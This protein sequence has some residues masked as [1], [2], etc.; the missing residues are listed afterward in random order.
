MR[1]GRYVFLLCSI[2]FLLCTAKLSLHSHYSNDGKTS[3][4]QKFYVNGPSC[5][6]PEMNPFSVDIMKFFKRKHFGKCSTDKDLVVSEFDTDLRQ[7]RIKVDENLAEQLLKKFDNATLKCTYQV[8]GR[9]KKSSFPDKDFSQSFLVPKTI[10]FIFTECHAVREKTELK[11]LQKDAFL[12]VQNRLKHRQKD[13]P[14]DVESKP[15]VIILGIDST[16]RMN[17]RRSMPKVHKF[18]QKPGWFEMQGYNEV[19]KNTLPNLLALLTGNAEKKA[20]LNGQFRRSGFIDK[21]KYIWQLFKQNGYMTAFGEDCG[22][23]NTFNNH[24]SGFEKQP[25]DYYLRNF[26][27]ALET[28]FK[29]RRQFGNVFCLGRKLSF[30][31]LFDFAKQFMQRFQNAAPVF[32]IFWSNSFTHGDFLGATAL[33]QVFLEYLL[34]YDK[35]GFFDRSIV[36]V[37]SDH[38]YRYGVTRQRSKSGYLEERLPIMFIHVPPWFRK[39]YPQHVENLKINQNRLSSSFD[40]HLTLHHLLQL[41]AT[42]MADFSPKLQ[43]SQCKSCQSLFFQL[44]YDRNCFQAGIGEKWCSCEPTE[45]ETNQVLIRKVAREVVRHMNEHLRSR[46]LTKLCN[47]YTLKKVL[48]MDSKL[49][50]NDDSLENDQ[51]HTYIVTFDTNPTSAHFEAT[52]Q[53]NT[54]KETLTMNVD[55]LSRLE[56]YEKYSK[57][58]RDPIVKKYCICKSFK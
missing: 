42:S 58:T 49:A 28:I 45:T 18:L 2:E 13:P 47:N 56:S 38:G 26:I 8:I 46:N 55:E 23:I 52:V 36:M 34:L 44:P 57:C 39:R 17:L 11:L 10:D 14:S 25:V 40:L 48:Y 30:K 41:N 51:L 19:G 16:S 3:R 31:Y 7:Y 4:N 5:K 22:K 9:K 32:G 27:V 21:L 6:M 35:L 12:F 24:N 20:Q 1:L 37:L 29:T 43:S 33:D 53:W 15:N 50:P 54:E